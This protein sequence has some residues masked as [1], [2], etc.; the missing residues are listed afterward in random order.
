MTAC[1]RQLATLPAPSSTPLNT[2]V[3]GDPLEKL[4]QRLEGQ[5]PIPFDEQGPL[6]DAELAQAREGSEFR[7]E[8]EVHVAVYNFQTWQLNI[9]YRF[10]SGYSQLPN[11]LEPSEPGEGRYWSGQELKR[12]GDNFQTSKPS[13]A[14]TDN[15]ATDGN[16]TVNRA[17]K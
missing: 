8:I 11:L 5:L 14:F 15:Q 7:I 3:D 16:S 9:S 4:A 13:Q 10:V 12:T 2:A 6:D 1:Q 17:K